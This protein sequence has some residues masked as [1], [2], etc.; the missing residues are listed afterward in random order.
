MLPPVRTTLAGTN[1][2]LAVL[3]AISLE[4][5]TRSFSGPRLSGACRTTCSGRSP[6]WSPT[7]ASPTTAT[8][9]PTARNARADTRSCRARSPSGSSEPNRRA[10]RASSPG[11]GLQRLRARTC[12]AGGSEGA[13][14]AGCGGFAITETGPVVATM[15]EISGV[16]WEPGI[17]A[18][19]TTAQPKVPAVRVTAC[20]QGTGTGCGLGSVPDSHRL[21]AADRVRITHQGEHSVGLLISFAD[22]RDVPRYHGTRSDECPASDHNMCQDDRPGADR[23]APPHDHGERIP[24]RWP[25][26]L[27]AHVGGARI[28]IVGEDRGGPDEYLI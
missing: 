13:T 1:T 24:V 23:R 16:A 2:F 25:L 27:S 8:T 5:P 11:T 28:D 3:P 7:G 22:V 20:G 4:L 15:P 10:G 6:T 26:Q 14:R 12:S 17:R 9:S 21:A 19:G 18:T